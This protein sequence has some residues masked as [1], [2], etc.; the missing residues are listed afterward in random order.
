MSQH[1]PRNIVFRK[2]NVHYPVFELTLEKHAT[3]CKVNETNFHAE[4]S[5]F[6]CSGRKG[7]KAI[8]AGIIPLLPF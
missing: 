2:N 8:A 5:L 6:W 4:T 3:E 7:G 1:Y